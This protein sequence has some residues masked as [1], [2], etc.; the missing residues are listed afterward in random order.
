MFY[1]AIF[2]FALA[3]LAVATLVFFV[4]CWTAFRE[5]RRAHPIYRQSSLSVARQTANTRAQGRS[6]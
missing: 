3:G 4:W 2:D 5:D 1:A 6:A